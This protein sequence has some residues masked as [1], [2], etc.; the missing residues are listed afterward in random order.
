MAPAMATATTIERRW[1]M[2]HS[3]AAHTF[4]ADRAEREEVKVNTG[5]CGDPV[6]G[7][8]LSDGSGPRTSSI[9]GL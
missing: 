3:A 4:W 1:I 9:L 5:R 6:E 8:R 7:A 2:G